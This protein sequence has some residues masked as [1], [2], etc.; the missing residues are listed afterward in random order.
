VVAGAPVY[1]LLVQS[2]NTV[3]DQIFKAPGASIPIQQLKLVNE[4]VLSACDAADGLK[5]G[6][7][8]DPRRCN[9]NPKSLQCQSGAVS[10]SCL[11]PPQ[12]EALNKAYRTV[13]TR[14][15]IVGNYGL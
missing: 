9:W 8:T 10:D 12:V 5:D 6:V 13:R 11:T 3:R 4:A 15:G 2:S 7:V 1:S 14:A